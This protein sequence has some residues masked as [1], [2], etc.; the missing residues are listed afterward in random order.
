[1]LMPSV[2]GHPY[3][4]KAWPDQDQVK[5]F[6]NVKSAQEAFKGRPLKEEQSNFEVQAR[7]YI[8]NVRE[9]RKVVR[10]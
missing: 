6:E 9:C 4:S 10:G 8:Y 7:H 2:P 1:M 5:P 3:V